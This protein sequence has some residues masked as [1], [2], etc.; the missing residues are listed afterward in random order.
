M[1]IEERNVC[2]FISNFNTFSIDQ[3]FKSVCVLLGGVLGHESQEKKKK[4]H[5]SRK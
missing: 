5:D 3:N 4:N 2:K 1:E